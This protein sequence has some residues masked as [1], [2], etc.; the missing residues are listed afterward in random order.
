MSVWSISQSTKQVRG[1]VMSGSVTRD[2]A[3]SINPVDPFLLGAAHGRPDDP[4]RGATGALSPA[5]GT[6]DADGRRRSGR[7]HDR[8]P[9]PD[10]TWEEATDRSGARV[11]GASPRSAGFRVAG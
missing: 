4:G 10:R 8:L 9:V 3:S 2:H 7:N 1:A 5:R 11:V 6:E